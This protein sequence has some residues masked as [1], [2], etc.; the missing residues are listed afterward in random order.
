LIAGLD[1]V[2]VEAEKEVCERTNEI[3]EMFLPLL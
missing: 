3:N 1:A 2:D